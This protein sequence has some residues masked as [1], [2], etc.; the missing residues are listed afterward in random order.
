M[1]QIKKVN[2]TRYDK[3]KGEKKKLT[4]AGYCYYLFWS[5]WSA[6]GFRIPF[7]LRIT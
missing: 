2:Y 1:F 6:R 7:T 5:R 4:A 3:P